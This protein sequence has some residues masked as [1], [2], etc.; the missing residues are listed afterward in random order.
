M[1]LSAYTSAI[2]PHATYVD[3]IFYGLSAL[4]VLI[5]LLVFGL[6]VGF[7]IR[8]RR[9]SKAKRGPL[10]QFVRSEFEIGWTSATAVPVPVHLLVGGERASSRR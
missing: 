10:P 3:H 8:Y 2:S 1:R 5:V 9:G 7:S 4:S 6:V